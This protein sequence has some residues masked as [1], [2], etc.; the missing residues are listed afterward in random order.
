[1]RGS[2]PRKSNRYEADTG[3]QNDQKQAQAIESKM[4]GDAKV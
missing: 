2:A 3:R 1:M 4:E